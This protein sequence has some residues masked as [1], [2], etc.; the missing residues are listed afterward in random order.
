MVCPRGAALR[1]ERQ[2]ALAVHDCQPQLD[3]GLLD[4]EDVGLETAL[5]DWVDH[6]R[7]PMRKKRAK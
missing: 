1:V 5:I 4:T 3:P 7:V 6:Q 2:L